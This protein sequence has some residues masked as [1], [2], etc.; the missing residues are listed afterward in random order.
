MMA[1]PFI[2]EIQDLQS[3]REFLTKCESKNIILTNP[4][5]SVH[6]YGI[7]VLDYMFKTLK[8]E[9]KQVKKIIVRTDGFE[10]AKYAARALK[11]KHIID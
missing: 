1:E 5:N 7:M 11:Y 8:K 4:P 9:F 2:Y 6:Y 10:G 3:A